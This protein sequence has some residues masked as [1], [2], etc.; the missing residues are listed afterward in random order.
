MIA[1]VEDKEVIFNVTYNVITLAHELFFYITISLT[2]IYWPYS[3]YL[4]QPL[5]MCRHSKGGASTIFTPL[6]WCDP[7]LNP[8]TSHSEC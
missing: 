3:I 6:V 7:D 2:D 1:R 8:T 4:E 5:L